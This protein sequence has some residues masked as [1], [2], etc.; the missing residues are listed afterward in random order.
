MPKR[1]VCGDPGGEDLTSFLSPLYKGRWR[2]ADAP[3]GA[4]PHFSLPCARGG[5]AAQPRRRGCL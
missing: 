5:G 4:P 3:E 1:N 2:G